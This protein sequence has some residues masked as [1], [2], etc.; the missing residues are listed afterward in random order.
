MSPKHFFCGK[1]IRICR[2]YYFSLE[3]LVFFYYLCNYRSLWQ[4]NP[5]RDVKISF[6]AFFRIIHRTGVAILKLFIHSMG[7]MGVRRFTPAAPIYPENSMV[8]L[9]AISHS[10]LVVYHKTDIPKDALL[11]YLSYDIITTRIGLLLKKK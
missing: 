11:Q 1:N 8:G 6:L 4:Y 9:T 3:E 5:H 2:K 10:E 7:K